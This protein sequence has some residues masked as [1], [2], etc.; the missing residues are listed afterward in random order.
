MRTVALVLLVLAAACSSSSKPLSAP[1]ATQP[2]TATSTTRSTTTT[3]SSSDPYATYLKENPDPELIL[4]REDA[5]TRAL[6]GCKMKW[7]PGTIDAVLQSAYRP[8]C[9]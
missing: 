9:H 4:S 1:S 7:A 8:D 3:T 2:A 5:Q 6:L